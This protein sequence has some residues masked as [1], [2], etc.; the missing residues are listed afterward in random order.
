MEPNKEDKAHKKMVIKTNKALRTLSRKT[1]YK[2]NQSN[3]N[4]F[5][6]FDKMF[7]DVTHNAWMA[8]DQ[9]SFFDKLEF[10]TLYWKDYIKKNV[11]HKTR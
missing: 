7:W 3:F 8:V 11:N 10:A 1:W 6:Q 2:V 4:S 5:N 9:G